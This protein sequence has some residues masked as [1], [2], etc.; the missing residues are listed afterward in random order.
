MVDW[1]EEI[2]PRLASLKLEPTREAEIVEELA[3]HIEERY[4]ELLSGGATD[5]QA[6]RLV[7]AEVSPMLTKEM[8]KVERAVT[9]EPVDF[10]FSQRSNLLGGLWQD[11]RYGVRML[12]KSPGFTTVALLSLALGIGANTAIFS[13]MDAIFWRPLPVSHPEQLVSLMIPMGERE[14]F[15]FPLALFHE[16]QNSNQIF[17]GA[18]T[19][20]A[21]GLSLTV[22]GAT[23]RVMGGVVSGNYF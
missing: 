23:E 18:I 16:L 2:R 13:L 14:G 8:R 4:R 20:R 1:K 9:K 12:L 10:G 6:S 3:Q 15:Y 11:L 21:D 22:D 17:A 5:D 7:L 19:G